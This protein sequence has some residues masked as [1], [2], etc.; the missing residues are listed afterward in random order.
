M[1]SFPSTSIPLHQSA[2]SWHCRDTHHKHMNIP[3][4]SSVCSTVPKATSVQI[5]FYTISNFCPSSG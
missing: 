2:C 4:T 1:R 5:S 3:R